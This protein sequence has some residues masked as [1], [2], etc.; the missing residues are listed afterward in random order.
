MTC[1]RSCSRG[2]S[3]NLGRSGSLLPGVLKLNSRG[4]YSSSSVR[5]IET[6]L[7]SEGPLILT[8]AV[9]FL[10]SDMLARFDAR[11]ARVLPSITHDCSDDTRG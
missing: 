4:R 10:L 5:N 3:S 2:K 9:D 6:L 7:N 1:L 8:G 11:D